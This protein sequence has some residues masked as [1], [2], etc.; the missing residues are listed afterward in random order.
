MPVEIK[1][2]GEKI[3]SGTGAEEYAAA[4]RLRDLFHD[5]FHVKEDVNGTVLIKPNF[6]ATGYATEDIDIVVWMSFEN[7]QCK[8]FTGYQSYNPQTKEEVYVREKTLHPVALHSMLL[9][10]ELK[11]HVKSGIRLEPN[12]VKVIYNNKWSSATDQSNKQK[13]S[14]TGYIKSIEPRLGVLNPWVINLIWLENVQGPKPFGCLVKNLLFKDFDFKKLLETSLEVSPPF[15]PFK[16][17]NYR[18]RS[19]KTDQLAS[20]ENSLLEAVFLNYDKVIKIKQGDLSRKKL[21]KVIQ[22]QLDGKN[23]EIFEN[24]GRLKTIIQ[25]VPGSGKTI[26]LLHLAYHQALENGKR[27]VILTYNKAL[28]ADIHR[29]A[30]LSGIKDDISSPTVGMNTCMRLMRS[31]LI[32]W[33]IYSP[34]NQELP[35]HEWMNYEME[36]F[37]EPYEGLIQELSEYLK[38]AGEEDIEAA[39]M[40][41]PELNWDLVFIDES[42]DWYIH[43]R[44]ILIRL[45]GEENLVISYGSHQLIRTHLPLDWIAGS[46]VQRLQLNISYRQKSNLCFFIKD[47]S[48]DLELESEIEVNGELG[49]GSIVVHNCA[50]SIDQYNYYKSYCVNECKNAA[51]DILLLVNQGDGILKLLKEGGIEIHDGTIERNKNRT[52]S[53]MEASRVFN[54]QSCR[55]LEGWIVIANHLDLYLES[56]YKHTTTSLPSLSLEESKQKAVA[57]WLYMILSR[58]IDKLVISLHNKNS[59][60]SQLILNA[61]IRKPDYCTIIA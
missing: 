25:G 30:A 54:Y 33:E 5:E 3:E 31:F 11:S 37:I 38:I 28:M 51:Y 34:A 35:D 45:F 41:L 59:P 58:P 9:T 46:E 1:L 43:E 57:Q 50:L 40:H 17:N 36:H 23:K 32:H 42:Q 14:L 2:L 7:Y 16:G 39:K 27:C 15:K 12:A 20:N 22:R 4:V 47:I 44:D 49:G 29:L 13:Y 53:S 56:V 52:P 24:I 55:G 19:F 26:N 6:K 61:A 8:I 21:E 18:Q 48:N 60:Y 10:I